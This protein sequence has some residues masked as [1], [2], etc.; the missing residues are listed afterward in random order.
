MKRPSLR[1]AVAGTRAAVVTTRAGA[2]AAAAPPLVAATA[3]GFPHFRQN[4]ESSGVS[5]PHIEQ[6]TSLPRHLSAC[7]WYGV[8]ARLTRLGNIDYCVSRTVLLKRWLDFLVKSLVGEFNGAD[9]LVP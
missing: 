4:C 6:N 3:S 8:K 1:L 2:T 7:A 9:K 5:V